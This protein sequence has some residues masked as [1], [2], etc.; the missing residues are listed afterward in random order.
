M[1]SIHFQLKS[2]LKRAIFAFVA[3]LEFSSALKAAEPALDVEKR[4]WKPPLWGLQSLQSED[5]PRQ[6]KSNAKDVIHSTDQAQIGFYT[7]LLGLMGAVAFDRAQM[8]PHRTAG[9]VLLG[10]G[11]STW[12]GA[13]GKASSLANS[14]SADPSPESNPARDNVFKASTQGAIG[15]SSNLHLI[16]EG[17]YIHPLYND[18]NGN[19]DKLLTASAKLGLI[20]HLGDY[21]LETALYWRFLTPAFNTEFES[22]EFKEPVGIYADWIELKQAVASTVNIASL[23]VHKQITV[24]FNDIGDKGGKQV[25]RTV[26][27]LTKNSLNHLD[28]TDQPSGRFFTVNYEIGVTGKLEVPSQSHHMLSVIGQESKIMREV[29]FQYNG[30]VILEP[31]LWE[32][33]LE[34]RDIRQIGSEVY[35]RIKPWRQEIAIGVRVL[36][37]FTPTVKYVSSH[38]YGDDVGQTYFDLLHYNFEF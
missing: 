35:T 15:E 9:F 10:L 1:R 19:T 29:G 38:L 26:H 18:V 8:A 11:W 4:Y 2:L 28:Y 30:K 27:K 22:P 34:T 14:S 21:D 5:L 23:P 33:A 20:K 17:F 13:Y 6:A 37:H 12:L 36:R 3:W 32:F 16:P 25:H 31:N 7:G 24:G